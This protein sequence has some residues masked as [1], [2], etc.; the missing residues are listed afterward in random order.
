MKTAMSFHL[1]EKEKA[2]LKKFANDNDLSY[3]DVIRYALKT[4]INQKHKPDICPVC[5]S[6]KGEE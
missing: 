2:A 6:K 5:G 4:Y 1:P 3:T